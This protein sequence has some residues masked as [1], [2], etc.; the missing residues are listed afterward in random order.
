MRTTEQDTDQKPWLYSRS[1]ITNYLCTRLTTL[2]PRRRD[3]SART[4]P[5]KVL[6]RVTRAQWLM[7]L[8]GMCGRAWDAFDY[9]TVPLTVTELAAQFDAPDSAV[10]WAITVTLMMRPVGALLF[11]TLCDRYGRRWPMIA[12]LVLL[13]VLELASGFC[14]SLH[15]FIGVRSLYGIAMGGLIGPCA[16]IA[17]EDLPA[18]A[19]GLLS[20]VFE[21]GTAIGNLIASTMY[22][23]LVPTTKHGWRSLYWFGA[24]PPILIIIFRWWLPETD[25]FLMIKAEREARTRQ[26]A[27]AETEST[28]N[29]SEFKTFIY[30]SA[31][32]VK[33][34]WLLLLYMF[35]LM[36]GFNA[37]VHGASDLYP[38]F[39]KNQVQLDAEHMAIVSIMGN[40]GACFGGITLGYISGFLGRRLTMICGCIVGSAI[41]PAYILTRGMKLGACVFFQHFTTVGVWGPIPIHLVT[42]APV[43]LRTLLVGLTYQLGNL[44]SSPVTTAESIYGEK[45]PLAP[46]ADDMKRYDY[47]RAIAIFT[48]AAWA[49]MVL[50]LFLGPEASRDEEVQDLDVIVYSGGSVSEPSSPSDTIKKGPLL[51]EYECDDAKVRSELNSKL[52]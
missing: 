29:T 36:T 37:C 10:T 52:A 27:D 33:E 24:G 32:S 17:L 48:A 11:G 5:I 38:T 51:C 39:L 22:R 1:Q 44:A 16:A 43:T 18:D 40:L 26:K 25:H 49:Y 31:K 8:C 4:S 30:D 12:N 7:F 28:E 42:L 41:L 15:Q 19:R 20:G 45:Y 47:G 21:G 35:L 13:I 2:A 46:G 14:S 6:R 23:A 3:I 34:N 9:T 50:F